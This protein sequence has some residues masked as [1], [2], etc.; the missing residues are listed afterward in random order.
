MNGNASNNIAGN[1]GPVRDFYCCSLTSQPCDDP[2]VTVGGFLYERSVVLEY[3]SSQ[4]KEIG[5]LLREYNTRRDAVLR[6]DPNIE[7]PVPTKE[8][9]RNL[10]KPIICSKSGRVVRAEDLIEVDFTRVGGPAALAEKIQYRCAVTGEILG[11]DV[12]MAVLRT[13]GN[14]V[15]MDCVEKMI[16]RFMVDPTNGFLMSESDIIPL[17]RGGNGFST[18]NEM[19]MLDQTLRPRGN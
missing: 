6:A 2:V 10:F 16:K 5:K 4:N 18:R 17:Q 1:D 8:M 14:V 7:L 11:N 12:P 15:T 3:I 13:S 19:L 9:F